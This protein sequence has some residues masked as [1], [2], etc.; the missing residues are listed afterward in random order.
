DAGFIQFGAGGPTVGFSY[1]LYIVPRGAK[2]KTGELLLADKVGT[3]S[4]CSSSP[5]ELGDGSACGARGVAAVAPHGVVP[6][7][8]ASRGVA[9]RLP[10]QHDLGR[11][12][13]PALGVGIVGGEHQRVLAERLEGVAQRLLALVDL[14]ALKVL[15]PAD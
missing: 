4:N 13:K 6:E 9:Q 3:W 15:R 7:Q 8:L 1:K 11:L 10:A 14:D 2:H 12:R 5:R